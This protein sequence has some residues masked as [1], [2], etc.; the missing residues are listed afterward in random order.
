MKKVILLLLFIGHYGFSQVD[1]I[2]EKVQEKSQKNVSGHTINNQLEAYRIAYDTLIKKSNNKIDKLEKELKKTY[3]LKTIDSIVKLIQIEKNKIKSNEKKKIKKQASYNT[4][5]KWFLP[6][7]K[8]STTRKLFFENMYSSKIDGSTNFVNSFALNTTQDG[9]TAQSE[10]ISDN[11]NWF[12][13]SFGTLVLASNTSKKDPTDVAT[14]EKEIQEQAISRHINAGGN[15]YLDAVL[16]LITTN[17]L[18]AKDDFSAYFYASFR[19]AMDIKGFGNNIDTSTG[20]GRISLKGYL[21]ASSREKKFNF[22]ILGDLGLTFGSNEFYRNLGIANE[23]KFISAKIT[24]GVTLMQQFRLSAI[25]NTF[26]SDESLRS[27][28]IVF[29][30]QFL[31]K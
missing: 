21:S 13:I 26:G 27:G 30:L 24:A 4:I 15:F 22:F 25:I 6:T 12:R 9:V 10:L 8:D 20:S 11:L 7:K 31:P 23:K 1:P 18:D 28:K 14:I 19:A 2:K 16:P 3:G 5:Y 17:N 29:G